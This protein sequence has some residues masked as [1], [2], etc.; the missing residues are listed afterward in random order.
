MENT[1]YN[2][3]INIIYPSGDI[4]EDKVFNRFRMDEDDVA[5]DL[6]AMRN[7]YGRFGSVQ[8]VEEAEE[9]LV[10]VVLHHN[11]M[12]RVITYIKMS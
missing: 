6:Q 4:Q 12:V 3:K 7:N 9:A 5:A 8:A 10:M 2:K 1:L 11:G